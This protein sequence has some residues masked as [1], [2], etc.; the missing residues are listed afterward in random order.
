V[1]QIKSEETVMLRSAIYAICA[2]L[3]AAS[4]A[5]ADVY[6]YTDEKGNIQ[7]T[8]RP[9]TLPAQRLS[10]ASQ[11]TDTVEM[12]DRTADDTKAMA[13]R[14][15]TRQQAEK[16]QAEQTKAAATNA[17]DKAEACSKARQDYAKRT[18]ALR[19]YEEQPNGERRYLTDQELDSAR[20][21]AK[22]VMETLCE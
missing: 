19:L 16:K 1:A 3:V 18:N 22:Q 2:L 15:K 7:Y 9:L 13:D 14:E 12:Q 21:S 4:A 11:R 8:D 6:K 10:I 5:H 20:A 17:E